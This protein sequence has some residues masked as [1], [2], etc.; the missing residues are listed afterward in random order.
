MKDYPIRQQDLTKAVQSLRSSGLSVSLP[1]QTPHGD[2]CFGVEDYVLTAAQ[3]LELLDK[4]ELNSVGIR[5]FV[6]NRS[7]EVG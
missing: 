7:K 6:A 2:L 1:Y 3:I 5:Q 4:N